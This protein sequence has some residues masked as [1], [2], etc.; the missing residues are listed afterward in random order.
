MLNAHAVEWFF[1]VADSQTN[2]EELDGFEE[3]TLSV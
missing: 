3:L 1:G 2:R